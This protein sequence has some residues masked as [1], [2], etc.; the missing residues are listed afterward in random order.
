[1]N[2]IPSSDDTSLRL[3]NSYIVT[4][5][6][7]LETVSFFRVESRI[8]LLGQSKV[9]DV[10]GIVSDRGYHGISEIKS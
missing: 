9:K 7:E 3:T 2:L 10:S 6:N 8:L 4:D 5:D 1:M